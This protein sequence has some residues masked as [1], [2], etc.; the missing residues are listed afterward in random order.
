[1]IDIS[2]NNRASF[3]I[4]EAAN[5]LC[6]YRQLDPE[7][8]RC[9]RLTLLGSVSRVNKDDQRYVGAVEK[10]FALHPPMRHWPDDHMFYLAE[11]EIE[12]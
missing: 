10:M 7:D 1:M 8:P 11:L 6:G 9:A 3:S 5:G 12:G 4:S 2:S